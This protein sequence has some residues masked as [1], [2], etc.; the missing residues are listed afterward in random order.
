MQTYLP[1]DP[2]QMP[3]GI[4][5][6]RRYGYCH[7]AAKIKRERLAFHTG[8]PLVLGA[9]DPPPP[10]PAPL[11]PCCKQKMVS[12]VRLLALWKIGRDPPRNIPSPA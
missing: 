12:V 2:R 1:A 10:K 3:I 8:I 9:D 4:R 6:I 5:A 11:C 7:P